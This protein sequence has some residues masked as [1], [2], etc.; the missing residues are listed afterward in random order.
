MSKY[1]AIIFV[2]NSGTSWA[3]GDD[4]NKAAVKAEKICRK[5]WG[6]MFKLPDELKACVFDVSD[7]RDWHCDFQG[8]KYSDTGE[9]MEPVEI[10]TI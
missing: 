8:M 1:L 5:D 4:I 3:Y 9:A 10:V 6:S 2:G 7:E